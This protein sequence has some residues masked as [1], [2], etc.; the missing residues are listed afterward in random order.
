MNLFWQNDRTRFEASSNST[1]LSVFDW[2]VCWSFVFKHKWLIVVSWDLF[3][4]WLFCC[5]LLDVE[6]AESDFTELNPF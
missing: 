1:C 2:Y 5:S 3:V 6:V 4:V